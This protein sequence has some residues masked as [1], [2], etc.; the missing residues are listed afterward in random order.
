MLPEEDP[1]RMIRAFDKFRQSKMSR[2]INLT[3]IEFHILG[4]SC[5]WLGSYLRAC[6]QRLPRLRKVMLTVLTGEDGLS[7]LIETANGV[8]ANS[9]GK[10]AAV[11]TGTNVHPPPQDGFGNLRPGTTSE[12]WFWEGCD[13]GGVLRLA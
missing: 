10:L 12:S 6:L 2:V 5:S 9:K 1:Y 8:F 11:L 4:A 3:T 13:D 7:V